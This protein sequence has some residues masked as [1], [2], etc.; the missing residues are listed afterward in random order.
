MPF[1]F[2]RAVGNILSMQIDSE[3]NEDTF[4]GIC[5]EIEQAAATFGKVRL[6]LELKHYPTLNSAED[7][8]DDLRFVKLY[9]NCIDKV[10]IVCDKAWKRTWVGLFSVFSGVVMDFFD[11]SEKDELSSW[12]QSDKKA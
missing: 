3:I 9:A 2:F 6:L 11:I 7:L 1:K 5:K 4:H 8:Y 10:A 12:I